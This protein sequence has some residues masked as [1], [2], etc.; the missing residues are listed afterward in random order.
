MLPIHPANSV[1]HPSDQSCYLPIQQ[2]MLPTHPVYHATY[3]SSKSCYLPIQPV[4]LPTHPTNHATYPSSQSYYLPIQPIMLATH[5]IKCSVV[6]K[7][8]SGQ[9]FTNILNLCCDLDLE[10]S[11]PIF[12]QDTTASNVVLSNQVW[13][14][15]DQK[16]RR[17]S[18]NS[19]I[20]VISALAV[21]LTLKTVNQF[22]CMTLWLMIL[23]NHTK[24][25]N[26]IFCGSEDII[27]TYIH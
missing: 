13:L 25:N 19:H 24:F 27:R 3:P 11:N 8:S 7:I 16:F 6:Q 12:P 23:H 9:T 18:R 20:L 4:M 17:Y 5:S 15:T 14:Q 22:F 10:C 2:I 1:T 26:K 21:T